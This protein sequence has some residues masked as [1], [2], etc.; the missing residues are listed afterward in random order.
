MISYDNIIITSNILPKME[1]YITNVLL[2]YVLCIGHLNRFAPTQERNWR[3][4]FNKGKYKEMRTYLVNIDWNNLLKNKTARECWTC[5]KDEIEPFEC[6]T[7]RC[8]TSRKQGETSIGSS[9]GW[10]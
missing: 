1:N 4:N 8:F 6:I 7:E 9:V 5:L 3:R 2:H 10:I